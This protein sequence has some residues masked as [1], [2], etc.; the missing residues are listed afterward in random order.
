MDRP[1]EERRLEGSVHL[2]VDVRGRERRDG[3]DR[4]DEE[5]CV[6]LLRHE[7][8]E[9]AGDFFTTLL[10]GRH[11]RQ[12]RNRDDAHVDRD[13]GGGNRGSESKS[14]EDVDPHPP[15]ERPHEQIHPTEAKEPE[16]DNHGEDDRDVHGFRRPLLGGDGAG[17]APDALPGA[18]GAAE[19]A[20]RLARPR[21][22]SR[23]SRRRARC[24]RGSVVVMTRL[25]RD[26][27]RAAKSLEVGDH[28]EDLLI[29]EA[30]RRLVDDRHARIE[31]RHDEV[32][33]FVQRLGEVLDLAQARDAAL[34]AGIDPVEVGEPERPRLADR[35]AGQA[36]SLA[37]HDLAAD[38]DHV[39]CGQVGF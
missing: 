35:V 6:P 12:D 36:E 21:A 24:G 10:A 11:V 20:P 8:D 31:S 19:L 13:D 29:G 33:G 23:S 15:G 34:R 25:E 39:G 5:R 17:A 32:V 28:A 7:P 2:D 16:H 27:W 38:L 4:C 9:R 1:R 3:D 30:D 22:R 26:R 18:G 14:K 37:V